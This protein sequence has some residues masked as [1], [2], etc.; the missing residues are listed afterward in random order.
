MT[1]DIGGKGMTRLCLCLQGVPCIS[2]EKIHHP[3]HA[4]TKV[5]VKCTGNIGRMPDLPR[6]FLEN[7][8]E[9]DTF[10]PRIEN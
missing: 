7:F 1:T 4:A 9:E 6:E 5:D 10:G 8:T 3:S 2:A